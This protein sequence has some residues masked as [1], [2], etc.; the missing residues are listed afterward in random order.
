MIAVAF[1]LSIATTSPWVTW[2]SRWRTTRM[3]H[4]LPRTRMG[5][6]L[7]SFVPGCLRMPGRLA[8]ANLPAGCPGGGCEA[9]AL[10]FMGPQNWMGRRRAKRPLGRRDA[11][12]D[13]RQTCQ[14]EL[15]PTGTLLTTSSITTAARGTRA[16]CGLFGITRMTNRLFQ[17]L[18][19]RP[20]P[21]PIPSPQSNRA[22][23][24]AALT[25]SLRCLLV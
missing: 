15:G 10:I 23:R 14:H 3:G 25:W 1:W 21:L 12:V 17:R 22:R 19:H 24:H 13:Y 6:S 7:P 4:S 11:D 18:N 2:L 20:G 9:I 8:T 16:I 5:H